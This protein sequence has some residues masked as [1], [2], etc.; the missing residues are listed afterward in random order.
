MWQQFLDATVH[1]AR[2]S[3]QHVLEI[4]P[5]IMPMQLCGLPQAHHDGSTLA[6]QFTAGEEPVFGDGTRTSIAARKYAR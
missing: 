1:V 4:S 5:R 6:G 2:Q 3:R